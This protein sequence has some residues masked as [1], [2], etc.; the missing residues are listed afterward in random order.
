LILAPEPSTPGKSDE[1]LMT[2]VAGGDH[3]AFRL[4]VARY[5]GAIWRAAWRYT[6]NPEDARDICQMVFLKLY[7][8]GSRYRITAAFKTYLFRIT[9]NVCIDHYRKKRP[10]A[11]VD[12]AE[13][14]DTAPL[15]DERHDERER[16]RELN[17]AI[18]VL[19]ERQRRAMTLRYEADLP[20][21]E[22]ASIMGI[23]PKAVERLLAHAR[24]VLRCMMKENA[25]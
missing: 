19:P 23:T 4:L 6:G 2:A 10:A 21:K 7:E 17:N 25:G 14:P 11:G 12:S 9:N 1:E 13:T 16:D 20:V 8:T 15:P 18:G 24:E 22:I 3:G 5:Q